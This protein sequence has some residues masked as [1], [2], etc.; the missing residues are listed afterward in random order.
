M[1]HPFG[2]LKK[3]TVQNPTQSAVVPL[4]GSE[5]KA[6]LASCAVSRCAKRGRVQFQVDQLV[7]SGFSVCV[8]TVA[9]PD[10]QDKQPA[11]L[12]L[13]DDTVLPPTYPECPLASCELAATIRMRIL[14]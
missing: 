14:P 11:I 6:A 3:V 1:L 4:V 9:H 7:L 13:I 2:G 8:S 12:D 5:H 10:D